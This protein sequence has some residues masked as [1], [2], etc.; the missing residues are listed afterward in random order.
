MN[1][2]YALKGRLING[3][4]DHAIE[5][6]LVAVEGERITYAGPRAGY[7]PPPETEVI[8]IGAGT[9][10]PG[11]IDCHAHMAGGESEPFGRRSHFDSLLTASH[12]L[13]LLLDAGFTYIRD[14][15]LFGGA[16]AR[17]V[18]R[19]E[20]RGPGIMPG[21]RVLSPTAGHVDLFTS[22]PLEMM[23]QLSTVG[24]LADGVEGCLRAV[25]LQFR[26][27]ARFIKICA[28]GGVSSEVDGL[29]DVQFSDA[30]IAAMCAE[31]ARHG[32]YVAAHCSNAAGA[33]QALENGVMCIEHGIDLCDR[34]IEIMAEKS[35]PLVT[36]LFVSNL[37]ATHPGF[38]DFMRKKGQQAWQSHSASMMKARAAGIR[39]A[40]GTD[41]GNSQNTPF[42]GNGMEFRAIVN[43]GFTPMEA[44]KIGTINGA[45]VCGMADQIGSL[46]AGKQADIAVVAGNPL[47]D[48]EALTHASRVHLVARR[49]KIE[50][51]I[52]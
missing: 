41:F 45:H 22:L 11:F 48:I 3:V 18:N 23:Q 25:R 13:S 52:L 19:G 16:L 34:A 4:A 33:L 17:A 10:L 14:M 46:E 43:A 47:E 6:G 30:E 39:I 28:T 40:Y 8:D 9:I 5:D 27:G 32:T 20:V 35:V 29:D 24:Y 12:H 37:V 2:L 31:A 26:E 7:A 21:G 49:G 42:L 50:K 36:T 51:N 15:S 44:I 1:K 38:P